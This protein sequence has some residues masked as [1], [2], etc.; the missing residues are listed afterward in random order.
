M[1][2]NTRLR[3]ILEVLAKEPTK[4][5]SCGGCECAYNFHSHEEICAFCGG[6]YRKGGIK[7]DGNCIVLEA[8]A[9]LRDHP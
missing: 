3:G 2:F 1:E 9:I 7:H 6:R 4:E 5:Q 8:Q